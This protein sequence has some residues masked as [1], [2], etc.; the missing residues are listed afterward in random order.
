MT[1][2]IC[3][4]IYSHQIQH[5]LRDKGL[6]RS[7]GHQT[8]ILRG[9]KGKNSHITGD[10]SRLDMSAGESQPVLLTC[11]VGQGGL[12][13]PGSGTWRVRESLL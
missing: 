13:Q 7:F 3:I 12:S 1:I 9:G 4:L 11:L 8:C 2:A 6:P 5:L 10:H